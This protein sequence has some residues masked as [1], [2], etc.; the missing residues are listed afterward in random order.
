MLAWWGLNADMGAI[1]IYYG[2]D[3]FGRGHFG[4]GHFGC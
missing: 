3:H 1:I 2:R 4:R